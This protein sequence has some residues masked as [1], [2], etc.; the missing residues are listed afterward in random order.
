MFKGG[1]SKIVLNYRDVINWQPL[2]KI[3]WKLLTWELLHTKAK[4]NFKQ[5]SLFFQLSIWAIN[6][7]TFAFDE[8]LDSVTSVIYQPSLPPLLLIKYRHVAQSVSKNLLLKRNKHFW[9]IK[10]FIIITSAIYDSHYCWDKR[11]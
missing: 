10:A 2:Y 7:M 1:G 11:L 5:I 8:R 3:Q 9:P 6:V 4:T